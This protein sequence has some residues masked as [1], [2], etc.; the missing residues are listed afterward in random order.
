MSYLTFHLVFICPAIALVFFLSQKERHACGRQSW[1]SLIFICSLAFFYTTPWDN[2][3][4]YK[5]VWWYGPDRVLGTLLYV[6][7][8][9][10]AFFL[11]QSVLMTWFFFF[12]AKP[13]QWT[14]SVPHRFA[15]VQII[16]L[17]MLPC[18]L[19][20]ALYLDEETLYLALIT[21]WSFFVLGLQW[22]IGPHILLTQKRAIIGSVAIMSCYLCAADRF[23]IG[24]G[25][26]EISATY[27]TGIFI[28]GLPVEEALFFLVT[29]L[30][31]AQG[32]TLFLSPDLR[33][34]WSRFQ[35]PSTEEVSS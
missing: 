18:C 15:P 9:E 26:W 28:F 20:F 24:L 2:Y 23:A 12:I 8:E 34:R 5:K 19:S 1:T 33:K 31:V 16:F 17:F 21:S 3:L 35:K 7:L 27:T 22:C 4:V 13:S 6:P 30:M 29:N 32:V 11:L 10:Y 25:I 14:A